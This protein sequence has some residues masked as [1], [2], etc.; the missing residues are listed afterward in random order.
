VIEP[1]I[2]VSR[3][4][5]WLWTGL[6]NLDLLLQITL[7]A[8]TTEEVNFTTDGS[9]EDTS[10]AFPSFQRPPRVSTASIVFAM[11]TGTAGTC[12]NAVVLAVLFFARRHYGSHVNTLITNQS[13]MDLAACIFLT[14]GYGMMLPGT[15][16]DFGLREVGNTLVCLLFQSRVLAAVCRNA[17]IIGLVTKDKVAGPW[18]EIVITSLICILHFLYFLSSWFGK[19]G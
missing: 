3:A 9:F 4:P 15:P 14:I 1:A 11:V 19:G 7:M 5:L 2:M 6:T 18:Y 17:G 13:A 10:K 16:K 12:A 8:N